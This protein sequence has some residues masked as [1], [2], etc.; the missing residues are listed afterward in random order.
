MFLFDRQKRLARARARFSKDDPLRY[1]HVLRGDRLDQDKRLP[2]D[3]EEIDL[4][5]YRQHPDGVPEPERGEHEI[6]IP[7]TE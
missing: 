1:Q 4:D 3:G 2:D 7:G 6:E 5:W